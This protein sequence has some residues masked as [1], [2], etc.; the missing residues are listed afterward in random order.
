MAYNSGLLKADVASAM[1]RDD[2]PNYIYT[3]AVSD[4]NNDVRVSEMLF[5]QTLT[6]SSE[7]TALTTEVLGIDSIYIDANPRVYLQ[8]VSDQNMV[9]NHSSSGRPAYFAF[10]EEDGQQR[11]R[12]MPVPDGSY[13]IVVRAYAA[14]AEF[15]TDGDSNRVLTAYPGIYLYA[16]LRHAAVWAQDMEMAETYKRMYSEEVMRAQKRDRAKRLPGPLV[17]RAHTPR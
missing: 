12:L 8:N 2:L 5:D 13:S 11:I 17:Q 15:S 3:M 1:G 10:T 4:I 6:A 9:L 16:S 7:E 14:R